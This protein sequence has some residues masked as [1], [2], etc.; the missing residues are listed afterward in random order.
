M[1]AE[2][3]SAGPFMRL[4]NHIFQSQQFLKYLSYE[5]HFSIIIII[6]IKSM[7]KVLFFYNC[8]WNGSNKLSLFLWV[9]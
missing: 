2:G 4:S 3:I 1:T 9:K 7:Q 6:V 5:A 8:I